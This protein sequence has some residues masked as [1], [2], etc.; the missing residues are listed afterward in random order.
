MYIGTAT[1]ENSME[2]PL[3]TK[4]RTIMWS[5]NPTP[6]HVSREN[7]NLKRYMYPN[8]HRRTIYNSQDMEAT[9]MSITEEWIKKVWYICTVEYYSAVKKNQIMPFAETW[10]NLEM[11]IL[12][13]VSQTQISYDIT[14][15][16][17]NFLK[18]YKWIY[19]QNRNRFTDFENKLMVTKVEM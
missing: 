2:V 19:S 4:N 14:Q 8:V 3:K 15:V 16:E 7:H 6:G 11:S 1:M 10:M 18:W 12:S 13:E 17:S 9:W 5:C